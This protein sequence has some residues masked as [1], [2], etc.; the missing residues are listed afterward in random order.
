VAPSA[1]LTAAHCRPVLEGDGAAAWIDGRRHA[2]AATERH[3][4]RD[5]LLVALAEPSDVTPLVL[6][7]EGLD[8]RWIG[9]TVTVAS[10]RDEGRSAV[11]RITALDAARVTAE[12]APG[13]GVCAGDSGGPLLIGETGPLGEGGRVIGILSSGAY[14]CRGPGRFARLDVAADWL[15]ARLGP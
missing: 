5:L 7:L 2:V 6:D 4:D 14:D 3:F 13:D 11:H 8:Q 9:R 10:A 1:V 12:G 15:R